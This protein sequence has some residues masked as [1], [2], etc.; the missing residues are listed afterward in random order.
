MIRRTGIDS[1]PSKERFTRGGLRSSRERVTN[2]SMKAAGKVSRT[3][4]TFHRL[5]EAS[6]SFKDMSRSVK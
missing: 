6:R 5:S 3:S 2:V 1:E 4:K